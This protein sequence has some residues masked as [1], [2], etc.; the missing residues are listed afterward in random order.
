MDPALHLEELPVLPVD[1]GALLRY[2]MLPRR[3]APPEALPLPETVEAVRGIRCRG[4]WREY[5]LVFREEEMDLGFAVTASQ[6]L[7][8]HLA[9]CTGILLFA[10]TAGVEMDR[11]A[12]RAALRSPVHGLL[13]HAAGAERVESGCDALGAALAERFPRRELTPRFSPGYGDLPL[14]LQRQVMA[15]LDCGRTVGITLTD[16]LLMRPTKS[17]TAIL[18]MKGREP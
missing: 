7:R 1:E 6:S 9:G 10:C 18:G 17:V 2:A 15:A 8:R 11:L 3:A 14:A 12:A 13:M 4:V 16:S 5:P